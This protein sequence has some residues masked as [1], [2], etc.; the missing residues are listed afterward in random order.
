MEVDSLGHV[1]LH[2]GCG[3]GGDPDWAHGSWR[4]PNWLEGTTYDFTDPAVAGRTQWG[5]VDHVGRA[6]LNGDVGWGLFE[7]GT[8][9]RHAPSGFTDFMSVA[10]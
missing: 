2:V 7:H 5:V 3:Y 6:T 8:M 9:G 1:P 4:G 10:P